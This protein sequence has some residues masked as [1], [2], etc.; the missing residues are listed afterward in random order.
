MSVV[1]GAA[2]PICTENSPA[3][4]LKVILAV[5]LVAGSVRNRAALALGD[6]AKPVPKYSGWLGGEVMKVNKVHLL[7]T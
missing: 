3:P 2:C 5:Q 7:T 4:V 6:N 1:W